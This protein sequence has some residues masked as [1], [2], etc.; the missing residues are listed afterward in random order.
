MFLLDG[1]RCGEAEF[2]SAVQLVIESVL[3]DDF[4]APFLK[5]ALPPVHIPPG[6]ARE[7]AAGIGSGCIDLSKILP[8]GRSEGGGEHVEAVTV[9]IGGG[10]L[11]AV[12]ET[13]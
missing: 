1:L 10:S 13:F 6:D 8:S 11:Q 7:K 12:S 4:V 9:R 5:S 3:A 2:A